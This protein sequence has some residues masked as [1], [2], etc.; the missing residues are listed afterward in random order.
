MSIRRFGIHPLGKYRL[1]CPPFSEPKEILSFSYSEHRK[2]CMDNRELKYYY[3]PQLDP[4][5][6][7]FDGVDSQ[8]QRDYM[9]NEHIDS[10]LASLC[11]L[12][13]QAA[14]PRIFQSDFVMFRGMLTRMFIT[15]YTLRESWAMNATK[16]GSAIYIEEDLTSE[17]IAD[18]RGSSDMHR[19]LTYGGYKFELLCM[20]NE[21]PNRLSPEKLEA[22]LQNRH[23]AVVNTN[24]E[25][26]SVFRTRLGAH[27]IISGA[28]ID[29]IDGEKPA[30]FPSR[31]YRELKT[32]NVLDTERKVLMFERYKLLKFWAQS[33]IAGTPVVTVGYRNAN[34]M[35]CGIED[36]RT[37]DMPRRVREKPGMWTA[38]VCMNFANMLL[39]FIKDCVVETGPEFQYRISYNSEDEEVQITPLGKCK[40]FLTEEFISKFS[41]K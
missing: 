8:I 20:L 19:K 23:N 24:T 35:L 10:L 5:P 1:P 33:F 22:E 13:K 16:L 40:P 4:A 2:I 27:S 25:Y 39:Q 14:D 29:C 11:H 36:I 12:Q 26:C 32:A 31:S 18:R 15:P 30:E 41:G 34:G 7:L 6:C 21:P 3:A 37:Q 17:K 28:E 9:V 38:N